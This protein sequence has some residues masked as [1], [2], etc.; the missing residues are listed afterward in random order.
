M[1][2]FILVYRD[3]S[4]RMVDSFVLKHGSRHPITKERFINVDLSLL[5]PKD[6][7]TPQEIGWLLDDVYKMIPS[8]RCAEPYADRREID[9]PQW[10]KDLH[11]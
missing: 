11:E 1:S 3:D 7:T 8:R 10:I 9:I 6:Y 2:K 4:E 5:D